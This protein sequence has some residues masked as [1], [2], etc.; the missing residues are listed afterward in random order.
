[1]QND[2]YGGRRFVLDGNLDRKVV[3][4]IISNHIRREKASGKKRNNSAI[5]GCAVP[6]MFYAHI[7]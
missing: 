1:M 7:Y 3:V 4:Y 2:I 6:I 5:Q